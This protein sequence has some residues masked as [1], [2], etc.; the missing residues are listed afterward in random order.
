MEAEDPSV[1]QLKALGEVSKILDEATKSM[2]QST[3]IMSR[4]AEQLAKVSIA[5]VRPVRGKDGRISHTEKVL[6]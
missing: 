3:K 4:A 6:D 2:A 5:P 1:K